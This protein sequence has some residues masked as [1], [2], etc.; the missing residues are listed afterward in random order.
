MLCAPSFVDDVMFA[1][2][3][4]KMATVKRA[5]EETATG[6]LGNGKNRQRKIK[7]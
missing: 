2:F 4:A 6:K 3:T 1:R 7:G 5:M